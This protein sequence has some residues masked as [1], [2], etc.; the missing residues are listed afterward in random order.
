ML[1]AKR[2]NS[3]RFLT[4]QNGKAILHDKFCEAK[5]MRKPIIAGNWKM[6]LTIVQAE[7]LVQQLKRLCETDVVDV[8]V[9]PPFTALSRVS[10][11]LHQSAIALGAQDVH[12][13]PEGAFTG[14]ISALMLRDVGCC[15]CIVGHSERRAHFGETDEK[16]HRKAVAALSNRLTPI[17][18]MGETLSERERNQTNA[19]LTRQLDGALG[20]LSAVDVTSLILAYEPVWAIGTGRNATPQQAQEVHAFIRQWIA[21]K[22]GSPVAQALRIQ[23]G[24]SVNPTNAAGLLQ[25]PDVDGAL[26]GGASLKAEA[27]CAIVTAAI[28]TKAKIRSQM[29]EVRS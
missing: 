17:V 19:S 15:Y 10:R 5:F 20:E 25:Q 12:W 26:V 6:N 11:A 14:E 18:C 21:G 27:F 7:E 2:N 1:Y 28:E 8:V 24:G 29:T 22:F 4:R 13:E 16:I 23:Y 3:A 9:C